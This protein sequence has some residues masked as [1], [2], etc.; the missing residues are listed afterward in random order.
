MI[1]VLALEAIGENL[2]RKQASSG[3]ISFQ[4]LQKHNTMESCWVL[5]RG[6]IYNATSILD[7]HPGGTKSLLENSGKDAT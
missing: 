4:E 2:G 3:L 5:V 7:S 6:E 1:P